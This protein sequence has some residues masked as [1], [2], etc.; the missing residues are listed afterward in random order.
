MMP[1]VLPLH[2]RTRAALMRENLLSACH[3]NLK[4]IDPLGYLDMVM[5]E[6][7]AC[8]IATD[9]GGVQK[10]AYFHRVPC[11]TLR[12]ETEWIELVELGWNRLVP[13]TD[14]DTICASILA[15]R[16]A[17]PRAASAELYGGGQ[18]G[19]AITRLLCAA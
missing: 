9:S 8:V 7:N 5:L 13:P 11:V 4:L 12:D 6:K 18:A 19:E 16:D 10:E 17:Q 2:P 3:P 1:V 15:A 14:A